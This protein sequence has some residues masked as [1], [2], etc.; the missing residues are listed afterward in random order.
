MKV[1]PCTDSAVQGN[2]FELIPTIRMERGHS[3][4]GSFSREFSSINIVRQFRLALPLSLLRGSR[5]KSVRASSGQYT[6][7]VPNFIQIRLLPAE[8]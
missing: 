5:P 1:I 7:S 8:L 4:D 2:D 6:R 3:V